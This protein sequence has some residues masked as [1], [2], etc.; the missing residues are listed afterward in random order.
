MASQA[1]V[2]PQPFNRQSSIVNRQSG[3]SSIV[4]RQSDGLSRR[5]ALLKL[6]QFTL[7]SP[8]LRGQDVHKTGDPVL[9]PINIFDF[10]KLA[11]AKM[12][13]V[14]WDYLSEGAEDEVSLRGN[15]N[16]FNRIILRPR[17]LTDVH[18]IDLS[19]TLLGN[20]LEYPIFICPAGGK[21]C[22]FR[23]GEQETAAAA[24]ASNAVMVTNG[25]IEKF[26][27]S[28]KGPK[29]WWQYLSAAS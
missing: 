12:D 21:S 26:L 10:E 2:L 5:Q 4:N 9:H 19:I 7:A 20:R 17:F 8:L 25:G 24:K 16:A 1:P 18:K 11:Q 27:A 15:R 3:Q 14:A 13:K 29:T 22:F 6:L 28:G 23:N